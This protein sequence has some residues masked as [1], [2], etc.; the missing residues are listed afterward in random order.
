MF[1][2]S[3]EAIVIDQGF[4]PRGQFTPEDQAFGAPSLTSLAESLK[5]EGLLSPLIVR[6][7]RDETYHLIAGERR[8]RAAR[9]AQL[10]QVPVILKD[11]QDRYRIALIENLQRENLNAVDE[12]FGILR[13]LSEET[14]L[15]LEQL[16][17]AIRQAARAGAPDPYGLADR[18]G[19]YGQHTLD[20]WARHRLNFLKL[21]PTELETVQS[22]KAQWRTVTELTRLA[23]GSERE[24][25]LQRIIEEQ[26]SHK[27]VADEI[28]R[29]LGKPKADA[30]I[31]HLLK[32]LKPD[33]IQGLPD[34]KKQ[35]ALD[36][37]T[38]LQSLL[39]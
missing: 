18:L 22:K 24:A 34:S 16:P 11:E 33:V 35:R 14:G 7:D 26:L 31:K 9:L 21:T 20:A 15:V 27:V 37:L 29:L 23:E 8:L 5:R 32:G 17:A 6:R 1:Y 38:E 36:L 13:L 10:T 28:A 39:S 12:T 4:N 19:S 25:L 3:P 30:T 2:L